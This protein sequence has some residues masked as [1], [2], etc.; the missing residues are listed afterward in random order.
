MRGKEEIDEMIENIINCK[1]RFSILKIGD[2]I[3]P[4]QGQGERYYRIIQ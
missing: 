4:E 3:Q 1:W 2:T